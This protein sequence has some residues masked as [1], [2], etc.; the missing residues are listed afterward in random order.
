[1]QAPALQEA[2]KLAREGAELRVLTVVADPIAPYAL[3]LEMVYDAGPARNAA[4]EGG[5]ALLEKR[6]K[7]CARRA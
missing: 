3:P 1:M 6:W 7:S 4:I 2:L 5:R